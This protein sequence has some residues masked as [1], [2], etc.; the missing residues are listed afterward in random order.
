MTK[1]VEGRESFLEVKVIDTGIGIKRED[2]S[3]L[4]KLFGFVEDGKD[5]NTS[6]IG[7]GLVISEQIVKQFDGEMSFE[8]EEGVGSTFKFRIKLQPEIKEPEKEDN[9]VHKVDDDKMVFKWRPGKRP[10]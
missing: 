2:Q 9:E 10:T 8:S 7:L 6:G 1:K 4:F 5:K 3:K